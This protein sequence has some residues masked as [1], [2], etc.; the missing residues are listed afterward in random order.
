MFK[1]SLFAVLVGILLLTGCPGPTPTSTETPTSAKAG[2]SFALD[3][4]TS[5]LAL[6]NACSGAPVNYS[7]SGTTTLN[8]LA[9]RDGQVT[10]LGYFTAPICGSALLGSTVTVTGSC[11]SGGIPY[12]AVASIVVGQEIVTAMI[13]VAADVS[14]C[15]AAVCRANSP[16]NITTP[17]CPTTPTTIQ[18]YARIDA[19][20]GSAFNPSDPALVSPLPPV[21]P[22]TVSP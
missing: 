8:Y 9:S 4:T 6:A 3:K 2:E 20:C 13:I 12:A 22:S 14:I 18:F 21:C 15:G 17:P 11:I 1:T 16:R 10:S 7:Y 5:F 19:S